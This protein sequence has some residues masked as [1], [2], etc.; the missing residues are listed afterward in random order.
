MR[1][2]FAKTYQVLKGFDDFASKDG[3]SKCIQHLIGPSD[4][5]WFSAPCTGGSTWQ[6]INLRRG[7]ETVAKI[8]LHW[9]LFKRLWNAFERVA[10]H[11]L[12][13]GAR[14]LIEWPRRC[15]YWKNDRVVKFLSKHGFVNADFDG[16]MY[17]LVATK[18]GDAGMPIQKPWRVACSPN[19][20][21]PSLLNKRCDGSHDHTPCAGVNT[22]LTQGFT[23]DIVNVVHQ[24]IVHDIAALNKK[25][26]QPAPYRG[27]AL[28][29]VGIDEMEESIALVALG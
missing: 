24:S 25:A 2:P 13:V 10:S 7:P 26:A 9:K 14:V 11:A 23:Q 27:R 28:L 22:L 1:L 15:A 17:G 19:S 18:G 29:S 21:L 3:I 20:S 8:R 12:S 6:F 16:C 4:T 5:L